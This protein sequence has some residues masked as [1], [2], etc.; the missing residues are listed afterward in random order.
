[1]SKSTIQNDYLA[2][3]RE[4]H[5]WKMEPLVCSCYVTGDKHLSSIGREIRYQ[6]VN[7]G[8]RNATDLNCDALIMSHG[9]LHFD[10]IEDFPPEE[11]ERVIYSNMIDSISMVKQFVNATINN[12]L[13]KKIISIGSMAYKTVLNGSSA[14]CASKA[15]LAHFMRCAAWELAPKGYDVF[16][17][18]P[19]NVAD[20]P[21]EEKTIQ[22]LMRYRGLSREAAEAYWR[23]NIIQP[24][25]LKKED[26]AALVVELLHPSK[27]YLSGTDIELKGGQR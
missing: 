6:I 2:K 7:S 21:M 8:H 16:S 19:S 24:E 10:W 25:M 12:G 18:H 9:A 11:T 23:A 3:L 22:G 5:G 4:E 17:I 1:M 13:R 14:Y 20:T 26:I 15:G 27:R